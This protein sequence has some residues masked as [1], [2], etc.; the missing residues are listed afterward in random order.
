MKTDEVSLWLIG[1]MANEHAPSK[2]FEKATCSE[3]L[4]GVLERMFW[5][6][7]SI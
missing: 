4:R 6:F 2:F 1:V 5:M 7:C 3:I